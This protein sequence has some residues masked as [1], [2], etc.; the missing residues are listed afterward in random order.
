MKVVEE[1]GKAIIQ[2]AERSSR[3]RRS[4][5]GLDF[6]FQLAPSYVPTQLTICVLR[7]DVRKILFA[8]D[9]P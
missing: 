7:S 4:S 5:D 6:G 9:I 2:V 8:L 3:G 1:Y